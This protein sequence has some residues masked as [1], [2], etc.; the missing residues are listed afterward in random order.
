MTDAP[1]RRP[2]REAAELLEQ[3]ER[4]VAVRR[5]RARTRGEHIVTGPRHTGRLLGALLVTRGFLMPNELEHALTVQ[6]KSGERLGQILMRLGLIEDTDLAELLAEQLRLD[7]VRLDR[8]V[9]DPE[10]AR[11]VPKGEARSLAALPFR[12]R[13]S[14][15]DV[16][17]ADPTDEIMLDVLT[18]FLGAP[19][20]LYVATRAAIDAA[21]D[22]L[23]D[24]QSAV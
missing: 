17:V 23:P 24:R 12:R 4:I 20:R 10:V 6:E 7:T 18:R 9:V 11:L 2:D 1:E 21:I 19:V 15:V 22:Q 3:L 13:D 14:H 16:A 8:V 5:A